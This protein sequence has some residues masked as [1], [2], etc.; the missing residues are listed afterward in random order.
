MTSTIH[1]ASSRAGDVRAL[2]ALL[3]TRNADTRPLPVRAST[4]GAENVDRDSLGSDAAGDIV[5][6]KTSDRDAGGGGAGGRA[7]LVVLLD[8][9]SGLG[10]VLEGDSLVGDVLGN[11]VS[12]DRGLVFLR[13]GWRLP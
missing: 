13:M 4:L 8:Q 5:N 7:V 2:A 1:L 12:T 3:T 11:L 10:D 6:G 9:N